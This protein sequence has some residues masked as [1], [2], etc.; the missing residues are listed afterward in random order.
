[1]VYLLGSKDLLLPCLLVS[2]SRS[3]LVSFS[4]GVSRGLHII[5]LYIRKKFVLPG[6]VLSTSEKFTTLGIT[7]INKLCHIRKDR[8]FQFLLEHRNLEVQ[9]PFF[10]LRK[11]ISDMECKS[12]NQQCPEE[13]D[14]MSSKLVE[15]DCRKKVK[16]TKDPI[17]DND[18]HRPSWLFDDPILKYDVRLVPYMSDPKRRLSLEFL[19]DACKCFEPFPGCIDSRSIAIKIEIAIFDS[20]K[21]TDMFYWEK[22]H[23]LAASIAGK[24]KAGT[25]CPLVV[26]G[27]IPSPDVL[28]KLP[29]KILYLSF[30]GHIIDP[31]LIKV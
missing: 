21:A 9:K 22:I 1:M 11:F 31:A 20:V 27:S 3:S 30:E 25:L 24:K 5:P 14:T 2:A 28:V 13:T 26:N 17:S 12:I 29:R 16:L 10:S 19:L 4:D 8:R 6:Q 7:R 18:N 15:D 23:D